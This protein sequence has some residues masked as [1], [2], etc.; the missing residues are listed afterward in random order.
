MAAWQVGS[1]IT[2]TQ[3]FDMKQSDTGPE[4]CFGW[5]GLAQDQLVN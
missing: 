3:L 4:G 1:S 5:L 2:L